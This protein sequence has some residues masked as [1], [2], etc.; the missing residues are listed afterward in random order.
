MQ[1]P[2]IKPHHFRARYITG[3]NYL[4]TTT[5]YLHVTL[6]Y[7]PFFSTVIGLKQLT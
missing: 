5:Y 6:A 4:H 1:V 2:G 3:S 7:K